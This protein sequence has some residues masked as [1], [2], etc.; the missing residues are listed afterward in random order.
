MTKL[1]LPEIR[2]VSN[3]MRPLGA[4]EQLFLLIDKNSP[5]HFAMTAEI[6]GLTRIDDWRRA[7]DRVQKRHSNLSTTIGGAPG[8]APWFRK[9]DVFSI[10]LRV[11]HGD[12]AELWMEEV[13]RELEDTFDLKQSPLVRAVLVHAIDSATMTLIAHHSVADGMSLAYVL[14]DT[15]NALAGNALETRPARPA[16]EEIFEELHVDANAGQVESPERESAQPVPG[17]WRKRDGSIPKIRRLKLSS[18]LTA[19]I[20]E[21]A[22]EE[23][24]TVHAALCAALSIAGRQTAPQWGDISVR[25]MS[26]V[27]IRQM[28]GLTDECGVFISAAQSVSDANSTDF[29]EVARKVKAD[30][31]PSQT[32]PGVRALVTQIGQFIEDGPSVSDAAGFSAVAFA[33]EAMVTNLGRVPFGHKFSDVELQAVWGPCVLRGFENDHTIGAATVN[34]SLCLAHTSFASSDGLLEAMED[35]LKD[36]CSGSHITTSSRED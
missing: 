6:S 23:A 33:A 3:A 32:S 29:W 36:A 35:V 4:L 22:R 5:V 13:A 12:P 24:T 14:R 15:L 27:N 18:A 20:M 17:I 1:S 34:G 7:L 10:P 2:D 31:A 9:G 25:I 30:I 11:V 28:L 21:R 19:E 26:P 8:A 16:M